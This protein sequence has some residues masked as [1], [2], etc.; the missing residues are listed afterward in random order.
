MSILPVSKILNIINSCQTM[1]DIDKCDITIESYIKS[2][3]IYGLKNI[4]DLKRRLSKEL[5]KRK[6]EIYLSGLI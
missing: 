3:E 1:E 5:E 6:E 2:A 4:N